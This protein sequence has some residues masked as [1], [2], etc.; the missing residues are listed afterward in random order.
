[1]HY[2]KLCLPIWMRSQNS[3]DAVVLDFWVKCKKSAILISSMYV[4]TNE[5]HAA[6]AKLHT[7]NASYR[8]RDVIQ[9]VVNGERHLVVVPGCSRA[10]Y[11]AEE[12]AGR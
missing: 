10:M 11:A 9:F 12:T 8:P 4:A 6:A 1:M 5:G 3:H 2:C 7:S